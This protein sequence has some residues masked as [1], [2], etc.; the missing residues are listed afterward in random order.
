MK[1]FRVLILRVLVLFSVLSFGFNFSS[2]GDTAVGCWV[3]GQDKIFTSIQSYGPTNVYTQDEGYKVN[4]QMGDPAHTND[5]GKANPVTAVSTGHSCTVIGEQWNI[6]GEYTFTYISC[7]A[8]P[9]DDYIPIL[10]LS[11]ACF[12]FIILNRKTYSNS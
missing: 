7:F 6:K 4:F 8:L 12:S 1:F 9:L 2:F 10:V 11:T 3:N 5:C